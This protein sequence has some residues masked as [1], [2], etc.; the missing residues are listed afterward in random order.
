[1]EVPTRSA[2]TSAAVMVQSLAGGGSFD[3]GARIASAATVGVEPDPRAQAQ[4]K[5]SRELAPG[6]GRWSPEAHDV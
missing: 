4:E 2:V 1:M 5:G 3:P 6:T